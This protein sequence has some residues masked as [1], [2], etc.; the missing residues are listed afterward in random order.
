MLTFFLRP[1]SEKGK[2][3]APGSYQKHSGVFTFYNQI[4]KASSLQKRL[5]FTKNEK[6]H[7]TEP[8]EEAPSLPMNRSKVKLLHVIRRRCVVR[9]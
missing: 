7:I 9:R 8:S 6:K 2:I 5:R 4:Y 1:E 3:R